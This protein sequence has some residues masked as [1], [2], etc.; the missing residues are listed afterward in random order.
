VFLLSI[1]H[2]RIRCVRLCYTVCCALSIPHFRIHRSKWWGYRYIYLSIPHF[3]IPTI[4]A[5]PFANQGHLFQF[6][7]LGYWG[8]HF[9]INLWL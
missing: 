2:F 9:H 6:L 3:R 7:I 8:Y 5:N 1:P 4:T